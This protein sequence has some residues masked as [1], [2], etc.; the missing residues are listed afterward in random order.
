MANSGPGKDRVEHRHLKAADPDCMV[1]T[2][3]FNRCLLANQIPHHWKEAT[4]ILIHKKGPSDEP[5]NFR[6]IA[7][8]LCLYKLLTSLLSTSL[9]DFAIANEFMSPNQKSAQPAEGCDEHTF[10]LQTIVADCKCSKKNC[11]FAWLDL[12]NAFGSI[13][14]EAMYQTLQHMAFR[15]PSSASSV[16]CIQMQPPLS[17]LPKM[18]ILIQST[19][20]LALNKGVLLVLS[21]STSPQS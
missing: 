10:T 17:V 1:L 13:S 14:H 5:D 21:F 2:I 11:F 20:A 18:P 16:I 12:K 15:Y 7:L 8:M 4:T 3:V 19:L 9:T 6:P